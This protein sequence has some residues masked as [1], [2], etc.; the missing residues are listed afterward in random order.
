MEKSN[1]I[2]RE[3]VELKRR[4]GLKIP[5]KEAS[6]THRSPPMSSLVACGRSKTGERVGRRAVLMYFKAYGL[7]F[8]CI[9]V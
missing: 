6:A 2:N 8:R 4:G 7:M 9:P 5:S 1:E 3:S